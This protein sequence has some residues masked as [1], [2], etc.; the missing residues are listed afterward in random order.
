MAKNSVEG[1]TG[2]TARSVRWRFA[3][4]TVAATS[5]FVVGTFLARLL[6]PADY[7]LVALAF[8][9]VGFARLFG[10]LGVGSAIIQ[11]AELTERHIRAAFTFS[12]LLGVAI[13]AVVA[14]LANVA[15]AMSGDPRTAPIIRVMSCT[16][17]IGGASGVAAALLRR[18]FQFKH[19]FFIESGSYLFGYGVLAMILAWDGYG[20]WS[21][22]W[23]SIAQTFVASSAAFVVAR[24]AIAPSLSPASLRDLLHFGLGAHLSAFANY[25]AIQGDNFVVGRMLGPFSLGLYSR[26]YTL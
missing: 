4:A 8:V 16:F 13:A 25:L 9:V 6:S 21:L 19:L 3:S 22:V 15:A 10:D 26:A 23:G 1:L 7:G 2:Q 11:R 5:Q 24:H 17:A 12:T 20:A 14:S 18:R